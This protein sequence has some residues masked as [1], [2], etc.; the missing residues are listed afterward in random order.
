MHILLGLLLVGCLVA[1]LPST[2]IK[3]SNATLESVNKITGA[4][5]LKDSEI[6]LPGNTDVL[7]FD[8]RSEEF[9]DANRLNAKQITPSDALHKNKEIGLEVSETQSNDIP[10]CEISVEDRSIRYFQGKLLQNEPH[11]VQF[12]I[13]FIP[14]QEHSSAKEV[15][16]GLR[17]FWTYNT[18]VG[19]LP[20]IS[21]NLD[22]GL[23]SFGLLDA[24]TI[25]I[26]YIAL[27]VTG[28]CDLTLGTSNTS[29]L[30]A[31]AL[32]SLVKSNEQVN[33]FLKYR[34]SYFC[35]LVADY[36][37]R[38][39]LRYY[40]AQYL[41][42][43]CS[44]IRYKCCTVHFDYSLEEY[45]SSCPEGE[46]PG[47]HTWTQTSHLPAVLT[48]L[49]IAFI[50]IPLFKFFAWLSKRDAAIGS[51]SVFNNDRSVEGFQL[52]EDENSWIYAD[53]KQSPLT[54]Y[55]LF[56][57][58]IFGMYDKYP[59]FTSR[60]RRL[61]LVLIAPSIIFIEVAWFSTGFGLWFKK[62]SVEDIIKAGTPMGFH[63]T[64]YDPRNEYKT[65]VPGLGGGLIISI[66]YYAFSILFLVL[67]RCVKQVVEDGLPNSNLYIPSPLFFGY[68]EIIR[69]SK[70][71]IEQEQ[72]ETGYTKGASLMKCSFCLL[73]TTKFWTRVWRIQTRRISCINEQTQFC[74]CVFCIF[75]LPFYFAFCVIE[76]AVCILYYGTPFFFFLVVMVKGA[77]KSLR[78]LRDQGRVLSFIFSNK[79]FIVVGVLT[80][81]CMF[82]LLAYIVCLM[83]IASVGLIT[84]ILSLCFIAVIIY[85]SVSFGYLFFIV[86]V[87]YY[88]IKKIRNFSDVY[89]ELLTSA[90]DISKKLSEEPFRVTLEDGYI[91]ISNIKCETLKGIN[92]NG[93]VLNDNSPELTL[94]RD[95]H[96]TCK[97]RKKNHVYGIPKG[98]FDYLVQKHRPVHIQFL[99]LLYRVSLMIAF[100]NITLSVSSN[101]ASGPTSEISEVMHVIFIVVVGVIPQLIGIAFANSNSDL[102]RE[103]EERKIEESILEYYH[104]NE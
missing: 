28:S 3:R 87:L 33:E 86:I 8:Q 95:F 7:E 39:T 4:K 74:F 98:L 21:W 84:Q 11:F 1:A 48:F 15:F 104:M 35:Y 22:Y 81:S 76:I 94:N 17:W 43:P 90:I 49:I 53:G 55:D 54:F 44:Y 89:A 38:G 92:I 36:N 34:E 91:N 20:F 12:N 85:P 56:S 30:I 52:I 18:S 75:V 26:P 40:A 67:P 68:K 101:Y 32:K 41:L 69:M 82:T 99:A 66:I 19:P 27:N 60:L 14:K 13:S 31:E 23:L 16:Q 65:F 42:Y 77:I 88:F 78:Y 50:P 83:F 46:I 70:I 97:L 57:F 45:R 64:W 5:Q 51:E 63:A 47:M 79:P 96:Q 6:S 37:L 10:E 58:E 59:I 80:V 100:V 72:L 29:N 93:T 73:F 24:K 2:Y 62:I 71:K 9:D 61:L 102:V 25:H 103:I